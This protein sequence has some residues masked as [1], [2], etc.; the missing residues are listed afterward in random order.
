MANLQTQFI[1]FHDAIKIDFDG[2]QILREKRDLIVGNLRDELKR[3]F[4]TNT[5]T[6][7]HFNQGSY[8]LEQA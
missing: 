5:P 4:P 1:K 8:D 6:F 3:L 2:G 7:N